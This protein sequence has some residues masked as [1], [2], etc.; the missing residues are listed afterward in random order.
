LLV[1]SGGGGVAFCPRFD[2]VPAPGAALPLFLVPRVA[3][4]LTPAAL[5]SHSLKRARKGLGDQAIKRIEL[6]QGTK[7][8]D[9]ACE[10]DLATS[11]DPLDR[12][13]GDAGLAGEFLLTHV[14]LKT[15]SGQAGSQLSQNGLVAI[16]SFYPHNSLYIKI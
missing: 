5:Q 13:L 16:L 6:P 3:G 15:G 9:Q 14:A 12:G 8:P 4:P 2:I 10:P 1:L 7:D 11:L